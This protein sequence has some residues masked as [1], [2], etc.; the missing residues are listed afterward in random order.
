MG[1]GSA[2]SAVT[3]REGLSGG[4]GRGGA[5]TYE[6]LKGMATCKG[7]VSAAASSDSFRTASKTFRRGRTRRRRIKGTATS[8]CTAARTAEAKGTAS[9]TAGSTGPVCIDDTT[10]C[11]IRTPADCR[12]AGR[13]REATRITGRG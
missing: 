1:R 9:D 10:S 13:G 4:A 12:V 6:G 7:M 2:S 8:S 11:G 3:G 5:R